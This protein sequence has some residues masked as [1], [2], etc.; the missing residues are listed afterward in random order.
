M[1]I[2]LTFIAILWFNIV[3]AQS[4]Q[5]Y[6]WFLGG[7]KDNDIT[8]PGNQANRFDFNIKPFKVILANNGL[9]FDRNNASIEVS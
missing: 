9:E 4:K 7:S 2:L 5:D 3:Q 6:V 1:K 8:V